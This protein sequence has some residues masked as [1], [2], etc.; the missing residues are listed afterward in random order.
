[1]PRVGQKEEKN[2]EK[3]PPPSIE[4]KEAKDTTTAPSKSD[5]H[6]GPLA[7]GFQNGESSYSSTWVI[8]DDAVAKCLQSLSLGP[9]IDCDYTFSTD[10]MNS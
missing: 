2:G 7:I 5:L 3:L 9:Q 10:D 1:M 6:Q 8:S 4:E